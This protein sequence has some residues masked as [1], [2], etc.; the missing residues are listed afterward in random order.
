[1]VEKIQKD[2]QGRVIHL[3]GK[4]NDTDLLISNIYAPNEDDPLF[5]CEV[6]ETV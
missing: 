5:F 4:F 6:L 1:M 2:E 3:I